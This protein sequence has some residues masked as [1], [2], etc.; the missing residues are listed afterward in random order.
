M[1]A[2][3]SRDERQRRRKLFGGFR[4]GFRRLRPHRPGGEANGLVEVP[5]T[6]MPLLRAPFHLSYLHYLRQ[7]SR[8]AAL[9]YLRTSL[10][11]C[12]T[13]HVEVSYLLH[14]L[15]FLGGDEEPGLAFFPAMGMPSQA[16]RA[17]AAEV[18]QQ[19]ARRH[20]V[21]TVAEHAAEFARRETAN[22]R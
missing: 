16:K 11:L 7:K 3:L 17:F 21:V 15:D 22:N 12:R 9:A 13:L 1:T 14:P 5:V 18:L 6:T 19:L 4:E 8:A 2:R 20:R 10:R